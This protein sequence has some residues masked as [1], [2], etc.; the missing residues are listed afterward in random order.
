MDGDGCR[1]SLSRSY[2]ISN[3]IGYLSVE[4]VGEMMPSMAE[5]VSSEVISTAVGLVFFITS[6]N[7]LLHYLLLSLC[8]CLRNRPEMEQL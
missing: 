1:S 3:T 2:I 7:S 5:W 6:Y 8:F 4:S